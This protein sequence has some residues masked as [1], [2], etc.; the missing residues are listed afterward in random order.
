M[1]Q[2]ERII[3]YCKTHGSITIREA[4]IDLKINSPTKRISEIKASGLYRVDK[5]R[6]E[7]DDAIGCHYDRFFITPLE[8]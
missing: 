8:A 6:I 1:T 3:D 5:V 4:F 2:C 7:H